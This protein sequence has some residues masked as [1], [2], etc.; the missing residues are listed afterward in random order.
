MWIDSIAVFES[1]MPGAVSLDDVWR[2]TVLD[3]YSDGN[4]GL[5]PPTTGTLTAVGGTITLAGATS[6]NSGVYINLPGLTAGQQYT[7][8]WLGGTCTGGIGGAIYFRNGY[9]GGSATFESTT[10]AASTAGSY[11]FTAP[12]GAVSIWISG[13]TGVTGW[14]ISANAIKPKS[15]GMSSAQNLPLLSGNNAN[16]TALSVAAP[17]GGFG[18]TCTPGTATFLIGES[19]QG[20]T[21]TCAVV[22]E[23]PVP[24]DYIAGRDL[25]LT[26]NAY[27]SGTGTAGATKTITLTAYKITNTTGAHGSNIGPSASTLT[28]AAADYAMTIAGATLAPGDRLLLRLTAALQETGGT[29]P[30]NARINSVRVS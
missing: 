6:P 4:V 11:T 21:K 20:N 13:Y 17:V 30:I 8:S 28:N 15:S 29:N 2:K 27:F 24:S 22:W 14:V 16:G 3:F 26:T 12:A 10:W 19:A 5:V 1:S 23:W 25:T 18:I 9:N 7:F